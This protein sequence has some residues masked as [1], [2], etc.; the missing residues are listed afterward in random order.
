MGCFSY[1]CKQTGKPALSTSHDGD[2][3]HLYFLINGEVVEHMY[4]NY[5]S[6]GRVFKKGLEESFEWERDFIEMVDIHYNGDPTSGFALELDGHESHAMPTTISQDDPNQGWGEGS[7]LEH[8]TFRQVEQPFH[9]VYVKPGEETL[10][11]AQELKE[12]KEKITLMKDDYQRRLNTGKELLDDLRNEK[13]P[14]QT[15]ESAISRLKNK[16]SQYRGILSNLNK[17]T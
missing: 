1:L 6:Y 13:N 2:P 17:L 4:G 12:L 7:E 14:N 16:C 3:V 9:K 11:P 15:T 5:N 10:S 8:R